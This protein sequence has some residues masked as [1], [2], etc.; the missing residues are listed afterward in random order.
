VLENYSKTDLGILPEQL[1][2]ASDAIEYWLK[3]DIDNMMNRFN[4]N[5]K[6]AQAE[7]TEEENQL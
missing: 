4:V 2:K 7:D 6:K 5:P 3:A 1:E